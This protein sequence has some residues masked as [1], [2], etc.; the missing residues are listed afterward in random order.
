MIGIVEVMYRIGEV[1][2][3]KGNGEMRYWREEVLDR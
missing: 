1:L 3:G 2:K